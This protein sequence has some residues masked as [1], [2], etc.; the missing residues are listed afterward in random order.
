MGGDFKRPSL[1]KYCRCDR[2][3][4]ICAHN[5]TCGETTA[6]DLR[7]M[8]AM[9]QSRH[10]DLGPAPSDLP[11]STDIVRPPRQVRKLPEAEAEAEAAC[12]YQ[13][14]S[15]LLSDGPQ[16][17]L[18]KK[19]C[20][21]RE[22]LTISG[23]SRHGSKWDGLHVGRRKTRL[24]RSRTP[25]NTHSYIAATTYT[26]LTHLRRHGGPLR[27]TRHMLL[28]TKASTALVAHRIVVTS[29]QCFPVVN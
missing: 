12:L 14:A 8:S 2:G 4:M 11:R 1:P 21:Q 10:F 26:Q 27:C 24:R 16:Q 19:T 3:I 9:G 17:R 20:A 18:V 25:R 7:S 22:T 5:L 6:A 15:A 13:A 29:R 28:Y 23:F